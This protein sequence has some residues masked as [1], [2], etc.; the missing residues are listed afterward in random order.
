MISNKIDKQRQERN[1]FIEEH[2]PEIEYQYNERL[3]M[4]FEDY[5]FNP[6]LHKQLL[7]DI[8]ADIKQWM[9][10]RGFNPK[11]S[12]GFHLVRKKLRECENSC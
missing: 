2:F 4:I 10:K 7:E 6:I 9:V 11:D 1:L 12:I 3:G 8:F 5:D